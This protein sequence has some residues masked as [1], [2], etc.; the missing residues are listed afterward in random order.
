MFRNAAR[1]LGPGGRSRSK[2]WCLA[3][4]SAAGRGGACFRVRTRSRGG[5]DLDDVVGQIS[6][7][8]RWMSIDGQLVLRA[9]PG[10]YVSPAELDLMA[11]IAGLTL[12]ER[13][14]GWNLEPF[15]ADSTNQVAVYEPS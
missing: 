3:S 12:R 14:G 9:T 13:W 15:T 11:R 2:S 8:R 4:R 6:W 10:R 7:S 1:H 5:G